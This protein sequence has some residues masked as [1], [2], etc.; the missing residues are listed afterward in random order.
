MITRKEVVDE[1]HLMS[2]Q[3]A[4]L[5]RQRAKAGDKVKRASQHLDADNRRIRKSAA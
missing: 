4:K 3:I 1:L 2:F 5:N